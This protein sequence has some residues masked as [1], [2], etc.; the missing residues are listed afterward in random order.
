LL[1]FSAEETESSPMAQR[2]QIMLTDDIDGSEA[3]TTIKFGVDR[4]EYEIDL[5]TKHAAQFEKAVSPYIAAAR[6]AGGIRRAARGSRSVANGAGPRPA[7]V[8]AWAKM[9]GIDVKDRG[10]VPDELVMRFKAA[11]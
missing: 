3:D 8:R 9:Q 7:D 10:R 6:K 4:T 2:T 1:F 5:N 11:Q